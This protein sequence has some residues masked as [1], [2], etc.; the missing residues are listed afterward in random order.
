MKMIEEEKLNPCGR[1]NP[2]TGEWQLGYW[3]IDGYGNSTF[4]PEM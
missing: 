3:E 4:C 2:E 1:R